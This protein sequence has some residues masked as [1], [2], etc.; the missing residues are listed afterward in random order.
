MN[1]LLFIFV[2][3]ICLLNSVSNSILIKLEVIYAQEDYVS[4]NIT[5]FEDCNFINLNINDDIK[6][7][8]VNHTSP[9]L[10]SISKKSFVN[11]KLSFV[12]DPF[13]IKIDICS[14]EKE[15]KLN[16]F[17]NVV[18]YNYYFYSSDKSCQII[19]KID[20]SITWN[21]AS[22]FYENDSFY[23]D[24]N[25]VFTVSYVGDINLFK[26]FLIFHTESRYFKNLQYSEKQNGNVLELDYI[27]KNNRIY[28]V[29]R[30]NFYYE[31][32]SFQISDHFISNYKKINKLL[33]P[34]GYDERNMN[35]T[36][37]LVLQKSVILLN[38]NLYLN[39]LYNVQVTI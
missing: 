2:K 15:N 14:Y 30:D 28:F 3:V 36:M 34:K 22:N 25:K 20:K 39:Y 35:I 7:V 9:T 10:Y 18:Y 5:C 29:T 8:Y 6:R 23:I 24:L 33:I 19:N 21:N 27:L 1:K 16:E 32:V 31:S 26:A 38:V 37:Y 13:N 17:D 11:G 4:F 12:I